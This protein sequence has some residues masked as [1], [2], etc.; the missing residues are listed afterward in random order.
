MPA[1]TPD[2]DLLA[3]DPPAA[4][5]TGERFDAQVQGAGAIVAS[6]D[7]PELV[8][9]T[10][11]QGGD[12][13]TA[14]V[15][16]GQAYGP[17]GRQAS[18]SAVP[19]GR[20]LDLDVF[21]SE[22][23]AAAVAIKS[24]SGETQILA[25]YPR[26]KLQDGISDSRTRTIAIVGLAIL[27]IAGLAG[28][29][30]RSLTGQLR[31]FA[32]GAR[33]V[34]EGRLDQRVP[35][36][37]NDEFAAFARA[38][39]DMASELERRIGE[40]E[41]ARKNVQDSSQRFGR[42]LASTHDVGGLLEVVLASAASAT[43]ADGGRLL[44]ADEATGE[45]AEALRTGDLSA[46]A[47]DLPASPRPGQGFEGAVLLDTRPHRSEDTPALLCAPLVVDDRLLG[48]VTLVGGP[49]GFDEGDE[50]FLS[51][52]A[53]QGA[54]A[55]E[56]ARLH[57]LI[58]K[59]ARTDGLTGL[60]NHREFHDQLA[61]EVERAQR[62]G[63]PVGLVVID[64][65]DFKLVND[66]FGHLAGD[67]ALRHVA[68]TMRACIREIDQAARIGGEE[69]AILLPHT[70][71]EGT[72]RLAER[73]RQELAARPVATSDGRV[74]RLTASFGCASVPGDAT[75]QIELRAAAD[76]ALYRAKAT[77][78]NRVAAPEV[79]GSAP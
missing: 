27:A 62:F 29:L 28:L 56:N 42:A 53:M 51:A 7:I 13:R 21:G 35:V 25:L 48:I 17:D 47:D 61:R 1:I 12:V 19:G 77:G 37:G 59:R 18:V 40:L 10:Q 46:A 6:V 54:V 75:T 58:E 65:D 73:V 33:A 36:R 32:E 63:V 20:P 5:G 34:A 14:L 30:V 11:P 39:N 50:Q 24:D 26:S 76:A 79:T 2:G 8:D 72:L 31:R 60:A 70:T 43:G 15:S 41:A 78:K 68:A 74:V 38:F 45:L 71:I 16:G 64:I 44:L 4:P 52:L 69:F 3:G 9:D 57:R 22:W 67:T 66:R 55:I 49:S 23:R